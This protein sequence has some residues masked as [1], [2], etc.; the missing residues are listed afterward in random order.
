MRIDVQRVYGNAVPQD[1]EKSLRQAVI[2]TK[3]VNNIRPTEKSDIN[4]VAKNELLKNFDPDKIVTQK[5][6]KF[7]IKMFP[8][9]SEQLEKHVLFNRSGRLATPNISKGSIVDGR[10]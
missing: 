7:F 3:D 2:A 5:E 4:N 9:S 10:V 6:R 8:E 1:L